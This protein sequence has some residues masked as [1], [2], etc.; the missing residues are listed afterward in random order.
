[1]IMKALPGDHTHAHKTIVKRS[2]AGY[3]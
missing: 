1:M 2:I 3:C